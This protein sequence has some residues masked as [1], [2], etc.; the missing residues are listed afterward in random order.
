MVA[1]SGTT[2]DRAPL[3]KPSALGVTKGGCLLPVA[4]I[5]PSPLRAEVGCRFEQGT[6]MHATINSKNAPSCRRNL[7]AACSTTRRDRNGRIHIFVSPRLSR[8]E[9]AIEEV[10]AVSGRKS[11]PNDH[12][13]FDLHTQ[14]AIIR[15]DLFALLAR[16]DREG[17]AMVMEPPRPFTCRKLGQIQ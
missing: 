17:P 3:I 6:T 12:A 11:S 2:G 4:L 5:S 7:D 1:R 15:W 14:R 9:R 8:A 16:K 10:I 13:R